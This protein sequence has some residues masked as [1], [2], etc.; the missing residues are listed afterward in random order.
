VRWSRQEGVSH[1]AGE[2]DGTR[3]IPVQHALSPMILHRFFEK[4]RFFLFKPKD[5]RLQL[6]QTFTVSLLPV[7]TEKPL[8]MTITEKEGG[9]SI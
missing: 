8:R 7:L 3:F 4:L 2:P 6:P 9:F 1:L 5:T